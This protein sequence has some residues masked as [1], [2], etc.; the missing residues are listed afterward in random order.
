D[1]DGDGDVDS[2]DKKQ[3]TRALGTSQFQVNY[4]SFFDYDAS[5][6]ID[7]ADKTA[8]FSRLNSSILNLPPEIHAA[9]SSIIVN[10][11]SIAIT[12]GTFSDLDSQTVVVSASFG[13]ILQQNG[14]W[15]WSYAT[16]DDLTTPVVITATDSDGAASSVCFSLKVKNVAPTL[17]D[18]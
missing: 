15:T 18:T 12:H 3:F 17:A 9:S 8:F 4:R 5:G 14:S 13:T 1:A 10:E 6:R 11:G 2:R 16:S 7:Q